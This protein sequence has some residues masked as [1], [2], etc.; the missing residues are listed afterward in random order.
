MIQPSTVFVVSLFAIKALLNYVKSH[1]FQ[2][3]EEGVAFSE[4]VVKQ[5]A[6][7]EEPER[8]HPFYPRRYS[9]PH[10][11]HHPKHPSRIRRTKFSTHLSPITIYR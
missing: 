7:V 6:D 3:S 9:V 10:T 5:T 4:V 2:E 8:H 11:Y 1:D